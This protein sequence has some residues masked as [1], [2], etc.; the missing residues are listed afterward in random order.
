MTSKI[1]LAAAGCLMLA[2]FGCTYDTS[3]QTDSEHQSFEQ[4]KASA[5]ND[6]MDY[7]IP[8]GADTGDLSG[9]S[10]NNYDKNAMHRDLDDVLNP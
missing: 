1:Y 5:E 2:V 4:R 9:G 7:K 3:Q 8:D 6:P 10:I